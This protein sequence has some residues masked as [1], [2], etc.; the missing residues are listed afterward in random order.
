LV[1]VAADFKI[2]FSHHC[3]FASAG[4]ALSSDESHRAVMSDGELL[5]LWSV[6][7]HTTMEIDGERRK[8][9]EVHLHTPAQDCCQATEWLDILLYHLSYVVSTVVDAM[10]ITQISPMLWKPS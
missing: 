3:A 4:L 7:C 10:E 6:S 1:G 5:L 2:N 9:T 8:P